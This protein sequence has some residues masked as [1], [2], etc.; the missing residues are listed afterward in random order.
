MLGLRIQTLV[1]QPSNL[2]KLVIFF[3]L[4]KKN[5]MEFELICSGLPS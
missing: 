1:Q 2:P 4:D 3:K 5:E